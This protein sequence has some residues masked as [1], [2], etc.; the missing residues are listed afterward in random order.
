MR[1]DQTRARL[2]GYL[3]A[4]VTSQARAALEAHLAKCAG[5]RAELRALRTL[6]AELSR[7]SSASVPTGLFENIES[8]LHAETEAALVSQT[9]PRFR[10][11]PVRSA[12]AAA[13]VFAV[14]IGLLAATL[15][16]PEAQA[17]TVHFEVL[18]DALPLDARKAFRKFLLLYDAKEIAPAAAADLAPDLNFALPGVLP[19][20]FRL[21]QVYALRFGEQPGLAA[22]Y[23]RDGEF[24][25]VIFHQPV[26]VEQFGTHKDYDCV[27]GK[28]RGHE[29]KVGD[30]R[31]VH[32]TDPTTCHCVL[33][34]LSDTTGLPEVLAAVA[35]PLPE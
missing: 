35:P 13:V 29:V 1:C 10:I 6:A 24:L 30:W 9:D 21:Q 17:S 34:K 8:R 18:L 26:R 28:H 4:E 12:M 22:S 5:C 3:D 7:P 31:L 27:V 15:S 33:S 11:G 25:G 32:L 14:G 20:G 19:G 16:A 23:D 2:G